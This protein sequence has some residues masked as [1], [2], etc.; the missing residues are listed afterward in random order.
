MATTIQKPLHAVIWPMPMEN[1]VIKDPFWSPRQ[2]LMASTSL[3]RQHEML[4]SFHHVD[5]FQVAAGVLK[6]A[7]VGMFYYDSDLYKWVEAAT[8]ALYRFKDEQLQ[9][10]IDDVVALIVKAQ[11]TDGYVNTYF[12]INFPGERMKWFYTMHEM[13]CGGHLIEAAVA[14]SLLFNKDD[15]LGVAKQFADFL[16]QFDPEGTNPDFVPG[17]Q[18]IELALVRLYR[19]TGEQ[20]YLDL[21]G[22]FIN[23]RGKNPHLTRT[24]LK[25]ASAIAKLLRRQDANL[26]RWEAEHGAISKPIVKRGWEAAK[27]ITSDKLRF[28]SSYLSGK[29]EEQHVPVREQREPVGHAVRATYMYCAMTD[30]FMETGDEQLKGSLDSIWNRMAER[31]M[32]ATGGIGAIPLVEGFGRDHE[33]GNEHAYCETCA[34][35]GSFLWNWRML[36]AT[37]D[38]KHADLME[39]TLYNA[40]L[41]GWSID[42]KGYR[43]TNPLAVRSGRPHQEWFNCA[44]CPPNIG[45]IVSSLAQ[46]VAS[47]DCKGTIWIHQYIGSSL[48]TMLGDGSRVT[49]IMES[50]F[51]WTTKATLTLTLPSS[52]EFT[53][54]LRVPAW[55]HD[56]AI[57]VNEEKTG[58]TTEWGTYVEISRTWHSGDVISIAFDAPV[59]FLMPHPKEKCNQGR[60]ALKKGPLVYCIEAAGNP[61][62]VYDKVVVDITDPLHVEYE[63]NLLGGISTVSGTAIDTATGQA[64]AF[65]AI[66]YFTWG[67]LAPGPMQ[68]WIKTNQ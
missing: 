12:S 13:Y 27:A 63:A 5:N 34:A 31:R 7:F 47:T 42:G 56:A 23:K 50:Q 8:Y 55:A 3:P 36:Q 24:A 37:G 11:Q 1:T 43:Y 29:Y 22:R 17:H 26:A 20:K 28:A 68:V 46:Y 39:L 62:Y 51:P 4:E 9:K 10:A 45:R 19:C 6:S 44:C 53:M 16:I 14:R 35:I 18:E 60:I 2:S 54:K 30:L 58:A 33:L 64:V 25:N 41:A 49:I 61:W 59:E 21:A 57:T 32:Y 65:K 38:A 40:I 67:N 48:E 52:K 15:L 66:P